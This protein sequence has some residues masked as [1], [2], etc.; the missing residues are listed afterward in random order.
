MFWNIRILYFSSHG[1]ST[2][3]F[4]SRTCSGI[5]YWRFD[6]TKCMFD[7]LVVNIY[8]RLNHGIVL[9]VTHTI[10]ITSLGTSSVNKFY[11]TKLLRT[12]GFWNRNW[13]FPHQR[14]FRFGL[15]CIYICT[16]NHFWSLEAVCV[17][18]FR[19]CWAHT[20]SNKKWNLLQLLFCAN[21]LWRSQTINMFVCTLTSHNNNV[22]DVSD[23]NGWV[24]ESPFIYQLSIVFLDEMSMN[25]N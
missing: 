12:F 17:V 19:K 21:G 2:H 15:L 20:Y 9:L 10:L 22:F 16:N 3:Q 5:L 14:C 8:V 23:A 11:L 6:D 18:Y 1:W 24:R 13:H 4:V 25:Q 7:V